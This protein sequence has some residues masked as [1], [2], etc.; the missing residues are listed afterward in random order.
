M[1]TSIVLCCVRVKYVGCDVIVCIVTRYGL[2]VWVTPSG[3]GRGFYIPWKPSR[4]A[5]GHNQPPVQWVPG[6]FP[7]GMSMIS[8]GMWR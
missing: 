5:L 2:T 4:I 7:P 3:G 8:I 1:S 6:F